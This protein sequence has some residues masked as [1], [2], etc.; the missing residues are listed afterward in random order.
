[1][2]KAALYA[3][4]LVARKASQSRLRDAAYFAFDFWNGFDDGLHHR[5][6]PNRTKPAYRR[7]YRFAQQED[8]P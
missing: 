8:E 2:R 7:G 5:T 4:D 6:L 3:S 1:M